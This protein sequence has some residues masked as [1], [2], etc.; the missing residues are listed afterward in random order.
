MYATCFIF[1]VYL[2]VLSLFRNRISYRQYRLLSQLS[3]GILGV[4]DIGRE[5]NLTN[6]AISIGIMVNLQWLR[7]VRHLV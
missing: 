3:I 7:C 6:N 5:G 1:C 4:G 2:V